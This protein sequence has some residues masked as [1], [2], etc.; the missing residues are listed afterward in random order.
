MCGHL[1][2]FEKQKFINAER[3]NESLKI[4]SN[5]GPDF[6]DEKFLNISNNN[7]FEE[8]DPNL[9]SK[10]YIGHNRLSIIDLSQESNQPILT[11]SFFF[12][13]MVN[14]I[15]IKILQIIKL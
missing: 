13:T 3:A 8:V 10:I 4:Q 14:F 12:Y 2:I 6:S 15:T 7:N 5:R 1:F 11:K 9:E